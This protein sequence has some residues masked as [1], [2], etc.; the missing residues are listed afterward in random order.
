MVLLALVLKDDSLE[1]G[2]EFSVMG[3]QILFDLGFGN[4]APNVENQLHQ[5]RR[6]LPIQARVEVVL[7]LCLFQPR[8]HVLFAL[9]IL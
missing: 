9:V 7:F 5:I 2:E 8:N 6:V 1:P 3:M 4:K